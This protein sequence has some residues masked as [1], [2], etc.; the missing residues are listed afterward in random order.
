M[1]VVKELSNKPLEELH[2]MYFDMMSILK[3]NPRNPNKS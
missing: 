2:E 1:A 3:N